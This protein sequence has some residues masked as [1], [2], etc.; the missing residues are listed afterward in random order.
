[1][2]LQIINQS[3]QKKKKKIIKPAITEELD[4]E[5]ELVVVIGKEAKNI[6]EKDALNYVGNC[7]ILKLI[8]SSPHFTFFENSTH[9]QLATLL[10]SNHA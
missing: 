10:V 2:V 5:V 8:K 6:Q 7:K 9:M 4:F 3:I 1:M